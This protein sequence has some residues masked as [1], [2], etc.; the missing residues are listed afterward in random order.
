MTGNNFSKGLYKL[1]HPEKYKGNPN[2]VVYRSSWEFNQCKFYDNNPNILEW[3]SEPFAVPYI[4][5]TDKKIHKY[6]P[7]FWIKYKDKTGAI[8]QLV[9][10]VKPSAQ[11]VPPKTVGKRKKTQLY[12]TIMYAINIAKWKACKEFCDK[13]GLEFKILTE[14]E[15]FS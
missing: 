9:Y 6:Y 7:D 3:C 13:Y 2:R 11:T 8:K 4:K 12:E 1:R 14:K 15:M 10:E 5:P